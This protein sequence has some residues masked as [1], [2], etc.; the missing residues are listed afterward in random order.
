MAGRGRTERGSRRR[1]AAT[2]AVVPLS[3]PAGDRPDLARLVPSG[4]SLLLA[5]GI[6]LG[7]F[8]A[9]WGARATS[10]FAVNRV[11]VQGAPPDVARQV[12]AVTSDTVGTSLLSVDTGEIVGKIRLLPTVITASV[13]RSF[14]HTLVVKVAAEHPVGI[15][16][17]GDG[18]W[19][20][21]GSG[22]IMQSTRPVAKPGLPRIWLPRQVPLEVGGKLPSTYLPGAKALAGLKEVH[23]TGR[24]KGVQVKGGEITLALRSGRELL[25]GE[26]TD[27]LLKL[28]VAAQIL[29]RLDS[30]LLYLDV[31][32]PERPVASTDPQP[33]G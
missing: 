16:R 21:T 23:F 22:R 32:I 10:V 9:Y 31:S 1:E 3:R 26:P 25:L 6:L 18:A 7:V 33:S 19:L 5:F 28:A 11:V 13:D 17:R 8:A 27:I 20:I 29:P 2:S 14:P 24:V 4:Q 12:R 15:A 30:D